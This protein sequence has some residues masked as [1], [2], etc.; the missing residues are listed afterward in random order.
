MGLSFPSGT[1][2]STLKY[3]GVVVLVCHNW[4]PIL[5]E[6]IHLCLSVHIALRILIQCYFA[7]KKKEQEE[8]DLTRA[9]PTR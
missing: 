2:T 8:R 4:N 1:S 6:R 9:S 5:P 7:R 3:M